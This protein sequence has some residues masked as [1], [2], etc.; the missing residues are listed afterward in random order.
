M[1]LPVGDPEGRSGLFLLPPA[2][3]R[4]MVPGAAA[5]EKL[6][7]D[8]HRQS[9]FVRRVSPTLFELLSQVIWRVALICCLPGFRVLGFLE[10]PFLEP[11]IFWNLCGY[12]ENRAR[13]NSFFPDL[14]IAD[15][16][17]IGT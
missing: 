8:S 11:E 10:H 16:S 6:H 13:G 7:L 3:E 14:G 9:F 15:T 4:Q 17:N 2:Q 12:N 1:K 5:E